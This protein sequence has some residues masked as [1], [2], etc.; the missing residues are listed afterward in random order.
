MKA[1]NGGFLRFF[2]FGTTRAISSA[3][4]RISQGALKIARDHT[5][6]ALEYTGNKALAA[7]FAFAFS[8]LFLAT[9]IIPATP[10]GFIA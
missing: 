6:T 5:M 10:A 4:P 2:E 1:E 3:S 7:C 8:A 9:A